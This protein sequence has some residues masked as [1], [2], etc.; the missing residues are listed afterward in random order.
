MVLDAY[1]HISMRHP[2]DPRIFIMSRNTAPGTISSSNDLIE[3]WVENAEPVDSNAAPGYSERC[4]HSVALK[5]YPEVN[6][7]IHSHSEAVVPYTISRTFKM[8]MY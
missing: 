8:R 6:S 1:G 4:I 7:V 3:Y 2:T 5:R